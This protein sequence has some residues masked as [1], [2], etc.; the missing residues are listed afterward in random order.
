MKTQYCDFC[1]EELDFESGSEVEIYNYASDESEYK[2]DI[3]EDCKKKILTFLKTL[4][5]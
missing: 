2:K 4:K 5:K 1:N 3:C